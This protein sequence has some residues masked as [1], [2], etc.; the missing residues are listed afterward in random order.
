MKAKH[1]T[2]EANLRSR[3]EEL[4]KALFDIRESCEFYLYSP[5]NENDCLEGCSSVVSSV[6]HDNYIYVPEDE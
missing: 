2:I 3:I 6:L 1:M 4:E 5:G